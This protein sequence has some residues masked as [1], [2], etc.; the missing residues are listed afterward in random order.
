MIDFVVKY[1]H[2]LTFLP[3][4]QVNLLAK[5]RLGSATFSGCYARGHGACLLPLTELSRS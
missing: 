1:S 5:R 2:S 3:Q 4:A